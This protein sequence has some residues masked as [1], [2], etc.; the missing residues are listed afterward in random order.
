MEVSYEEGGKLLTT[1]D[2]EAVIEE[3]RIKPSKMMV[4][5]EHMKKELKA[6][7]RLSRA[8][9]GFHGRRCFKRTLRGTDYIC[10]SRKAVGMS[11]MQSSIFQDYHEV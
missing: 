3:V 5:Q 6:Q 8:K 9:R 2:L 1:D 10:Q 11:Y 4:Y 7:L